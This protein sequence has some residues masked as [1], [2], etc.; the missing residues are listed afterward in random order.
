MNHST[1]RR[2]RNS[3]R[4]DWIVLLLAL[5]VL[6][7]ALGYYLYSK[8]ESRESFEVVCVFLIP[9]VERQDWE[10]YGGE[11]IREGDP[12]RSENGTVRLGE[13]ESVEAVPHLRATVRDGIP[14]WEPHPYLTDLEIT[15]RMTVTRRE[16]DGLRAGDLRIAAGGSGNFRFGGYLSHAELISV[17]EKTA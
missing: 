16:G 17:K 7:A 12:L 3:R 4:M 13:I 10:R 15:V 1:D 6:I 5:A 8:K 2:R 9:S 11:W 14:T